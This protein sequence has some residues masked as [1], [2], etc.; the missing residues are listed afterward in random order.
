LI[1]THTAI[2]C[3]AVT[4]ADTLIVTHT[5]ITC[6]AVTDADTLIVDGQVVDGRSVRLCGRQRL[7][8]IP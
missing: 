2:T 3:E 4:D 7:M 6:E 5:A 1:V 8:L